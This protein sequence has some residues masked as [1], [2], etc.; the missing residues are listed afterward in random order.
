MNNDIGDFAQSINRLHEKSGL[1]WRQVGRLFDVSERT[2][3][4][5]TSGYAEPIKSADKRCHELLIRLAAVPDKTPEE[6]RKWFL[7]S[8]QGKSTYALWCDEVHVDSPK[9]QLSFFDMYRGKFWR[10]EE[11][12]NERSD[13]NDN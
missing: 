9:L 1:S 11:E 3:R 2:V 5:W 4:W 8:N 13:N 7:S 10:S 6:M 12:P